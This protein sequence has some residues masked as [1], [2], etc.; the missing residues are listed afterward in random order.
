MKLITTLLPLAAFT[1]AFVIP[2]EEVASQ[3]VLESQKESQTFLDRLQGGVEDVWSDVEESFK[4]AVAFGGNAIDNA[5]NAASEAG[6]QIKNTFECH[7]SMTKFDT[8]GWLDSA[9]S[10]VE[11][12]DIPWTE[13]DGHHKPPHHGRPH[14]PHR[15]HP[16][17]KH[18]HANKTV[19]QLISES[20]YTT[21]LAKLIN[22]YPDLVDALNG[23]AA[24]YT[25]F[26]PTDA[27][28]EKIPKHGK[29][30][31]KE[32]IKKVLAYHVSPEY[33]PAGRVLVTHT[34]PTILGEDALGGEPQRLRVGFGIPKGLNINFYSKII[35]I[36]IFGSNGVIHGIDSLLLPPPPATTIISLL[37]GEFS[38]LQLALVKTGLF[39]ALKEA[40]HTGGTFFAPSNFAFK[41]L[42]PKIN[43]FLFS[44]Y[45]EKY[46]KALLKYHVV[47]NQTLY[48][49]AFYKAKN[50]EGE[51]MDFEGEEIPKGRFHV[52]LPT[53]LED[54]SLAIDVARYGG[55]I[56]IKINGFSGVAV[57]DGIARDGVIHILSSIL[58]PPKTPGGASEMVEEEMDLEEFKERLE[59][60][61]KEL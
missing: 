12:V 58:I 42:G 30:P 25:V 10:T 45:G 6:E 23:T 16:P 37:P 9:I 5:L 46:L 44:K 20:K 57:Q 8:Q 24:N 28:F 32:L 34:I 35:A 39:D 49:D 54:K 18:G 7:H 15:G 38:T 11:D 41:K 40:P 19:Y 17:H 53:L 36:N 50:V 52:D 3:L 47:A 22:E 61:Y 55:W 59:V 1:S 14:K 21:K 26:A 33:Y 4:D 43:A 13:D 60:F 27:A 29:K 31:S 48:S 56:T 2:D 51:G